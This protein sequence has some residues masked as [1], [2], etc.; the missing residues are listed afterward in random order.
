MKKVLVLGGGGFIGRSIT[1]FL[2]DRNDCYVTAADTKKDS[3]WKNLKKSSKNFDYIVADFTDIKSFDLFKHSYDE[4]YHLA[5]IVGVNKTLEN[6]EQVIRINTLL[7]MNMLDWISKNPIKK[8]VFSSTSETYAGTTDLFDVEVPTSEDVPLCI[9]DIKHPR[10]TYAIS[11]MH[12]ESAF[13]HSSKAEKY[14]CAIVRYHN[15]IGPNMGFN[16]AIAHIVE[17]FFNKEKSPFKIYG[18]D[19]TRAFCYIDDAVIGTVKAMELNTNGEV[20]HIGNDQEITIESLTC[21][22]GK[23]MGYEDKYE[24]AMKYPG[25]VARRCPNITKARSVLN[26]EPRINWEKAVELTVDWYKEFYSKGNKP[27]MG[28]FKPPE[29]IL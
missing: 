26:Y 20:F 19:Q 18:H 12:G 15:I 13:L 1:S 16:H 3:S 8:I 17:R 14:E 24:P 6:P 5:A 29:K 2:V 28:G 21:Y 27:K 7:T 25:S 23:L 10:W 11:K 22:I 4:I 9:S